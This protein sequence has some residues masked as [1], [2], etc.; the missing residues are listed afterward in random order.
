MT[1]DFYTD[2]SRYSNYIL[3]RG[4]RN[5]KQ[6]SER[7]KYE[8]SLWVRSQKETNTRGFIDGNF[9]SRKKFP[10]ISD[11]SDYINSYKDVSGMDMYGNTNYIA[12][13]IQ[14]YYPTEIQFDM[15]LINIFNFDIEVDTEKKLPNIK[16][17][18]NEIISVS[19]KSSK[20]DFYHLIGLKDFDPTKTVSNIDPSKIIYTKVSSEKE[21]LLKFISIWCSDY[22]DIVTGWNVEYFDIWYLISRIIKV[23]GEGA[24]KQLSPWKFIKKETRELFKR[25]QSTY[26]IVG[27]SII[28]YMD[29]FKKFG[30]KYGPQETY[31]LDHIANVVLG[32]KKLDYSEYGSLA[33]LY[34]Q[35]PQLFLDYNLVDTHLIQ[36]LEDETAL[37]SL[38]LTIAYSGGVNYQEAFGTVGIWETIIYRNLL[39]RGIVPKI[40]SGPGE[41]AELLGGHVKVPVP[42]MYRW[43]V[44]LDLA[45]LYP[46]LI[47]QFN[48]SP[49]TFMR[50]HK[51]YISQEMIISGDYNKATEYSVA[52]NGA[53]FS[54]STIGI[55]PEIIQQEYDSRSVVKK[56]MLLV[57]QKLEYEEDPNEKLKLKRLAT[58]LHNKQMSIKIKMN[59]IFGALGNRYFLYYI[60]DVAEAITSAGQ[61]A[62]KKAEQSINTYL[63]KALKTKDIDYV[64]YC[65]TDSIFVR[66][67]SLIEKVFGTLDIE[68]SVAENFIDKVCKEKL[69]TAIKDGYEDLAKQLSVFRNAMSMKR[70]K[71]TKNLLMVAKKRYIANVLN[72]EGV[73]YSIPKISVTGVESVRSS[74]PEICR[75]KMEELFEIIMNGTERDTQNFIQNFKTEFNQLPLDQISKISGTDDI[76]KYMDPKTLYKKGCPIHVRGCIV[77]NDFLERKNIAHKYEKIQSGDKIKFI[78]LKLPN[79]LRENIISFPFTLPKEFDLEKYVDYNLQFEKV[80]LTPIKNI[81]DS[82]NWNVEKINTLE[83]FFV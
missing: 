37:L 42:G 47:M 55:I 5:G 62:I 53:C 64:I 28:D 13:F 50:D 24:A 77:Y 56:E 8:P 82:I 69:E 19:I 6:F 10:S 78:Y 66:L 65:D 80:F 43:A 31:K 15:S 22:P 48:M 17:P 51:E 25:Q 21:L 34:K 83:S 16:D 54:N 1:S 61:I 38:V 71:I 35:N 4:Y 3:L 12:Q 26:N 9:L 57:E 67:D 52:P 75:T 72:N 41:S 59:S 14:E 30:Y 60:N 79:P 74:T 70:E 11:L 2:V 49:E 39:S 58:Q 29:A 44:T 81:L 23:L 73:H 20:S 18:D 33:E 7:I 32:L 46:H 76:E 27:I 45:S 68:N 36:M 40:K 63:N